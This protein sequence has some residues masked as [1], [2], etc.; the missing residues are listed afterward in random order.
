M[1]STLCASSWK[2]FSSRLALLFLV[3]VLP[4]ADPARS[5]TPPAPSARAAALVRQLGSP[6]FAEREH[7]ARELTSLGIAAQDALAAAQNDPDAE[8]RTRARAILTAVTETDFR[9]RV[10]AFSADYD[11]SRGQTL[12]GWERF[13]KTFGTSHQARQLFVEMAREEHELLVA[14]AAGGATANAALDARCQ[15]LL[16]QFMQISS[17][18]TLLPLGT[19]A[20]LLAVGSADD[21]RVDEQ[22]GVQL[23]TWMIYQPAF[24]RNAR[25]GPWSGLMK[26][27][28]GQWI[29]KESGTSTT[30]Q[31][32]LFAA[33]Y[34]LKAEGLTVSQRILNGDAQQNVQLRQ[35][36]ILGIGRFGGKEHIALIEKYLEDP[37][38]C[39]AIQVS[40]P[41]RQVDVR[42]SD[43]TLAVLLHL[44]GQPAGEYG[45]TVPQASPQSSFQ[46]P[47]LGFVDE[48][49]REKA[50][51][52]WKEWHAAHP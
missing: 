16:Q 46:I 10:E 50:M 20:A 2:R 41:P 44:T 13:S 19:V 37:T 36:A 25:P 40:D 51:Q 31:N 28:L 23:Y 6:K 48:A 30:M 4:A 15:S 1:R 17:G 39:G 27:L 47:A 11:G 5:A 9:G 7:A 14:Y 32:L 24:A 29:V 12:P 35:F 42:M 21:V 43:V 49:Q 45:T 8:L 18:E 3:A 38:N 52:R 26:K 34:D 22:L 33:A